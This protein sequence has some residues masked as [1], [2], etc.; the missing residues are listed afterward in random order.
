LL[1]LLLNPENLG[2]LIKDFARE[3]N[4]D[5]SLDFVSSEHPKL[6]ACFFDGVNCVPGFIL[7]LVFDSCGTK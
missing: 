4:I 7:N 2:S 5:S 6:D 1:A 3:S